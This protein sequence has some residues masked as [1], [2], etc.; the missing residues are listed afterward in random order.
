MGP[1]ANINNVRR[2][3]TLT[4]FN[5][6][7]DSQGVDNV[8]METKVPM[9]ENNVY[10]SAKVMAVAVDPMRINE[11]QTALTASDHPV[12]SHPTSYLET[13]THLLRG[14]IGSGMMAMGDAF[15]HAGLLVGPLV[16][17]FLG[18]VCVHSQH[19]LLC[20]S[21]E[22][23][24]RT[25]AKTLPHFA[26]TVEMCFQTGPQ[27][28]RRFAGTIRWL[29]DV[30]LCITQL[31]FCCVYFVFIAENI[32]Q[33]MDVYAPQN[34]LDI[35]LHM[36]IVFFPILLSC[37]IRN[38]KYL[39]PVSSIA[40]VLMAAGIVAT[41]YVVVQD[42]P[43]VDERPFVG[44]LSDLPLFFGTAI[45]AFEGIGLVLPL[46]EQMKKPTQ[47]TARFG[48]LNVG[49]VIVAALF[50]TMGF[51]GYLK[52]GD[53]IMGSITLNLP[54]HD[55]LSQ[56]IK[57]AIALGILLTY[58]L[59]MYV[60]VRIIWSGVEKHYGPFKHPV[61]C[62]IAFRTVLVTVTFILAEAIPKLGLFISLVGA[63][64]SCAL[65]LLFP[66]IIDVVLRWETTGLGRCKWILWK[67][68]FIFVVG[69]AGAVT[70]TFY[71]I[72]A[73]INAFI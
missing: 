57:L 63:F 34:K 11:S 41:L 36:F 20:A 60:P 15:K 9:P 52:Y 28:L 16:T 71:S 26:E 68:I 17:L 1:E 24:E 38:L 44:P 32:K 3:I 42:L 27:K 73:I 40:N 7:K 22:M 8:A 59:Q 65:A 55:V 13:L 14:N 70:G 69:I 35:H 61:F 58:A 4:M 23:A 50:V 48:V 43:S 6:K 49:M 53:G 18:V 21:R 12:V 2:Y 56:C 25:K 67:D 39:A 19:I 45:Y 29:V 47:F 33:V 72:E 46:Q 30:F 64:S 31:G 10:G 62:E 54:D 66:A 5:K 37:W 51:L